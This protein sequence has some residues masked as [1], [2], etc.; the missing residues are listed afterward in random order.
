MSGLVTNN[1]NAAV[2]GCE[3]VYGINYGFLDTDSSLQGEENSFKL[4]EFIGKIEM[5]FL[6]ILREQIKFQ[7]LKDKY[8]PKSTKSYE[9]RDL[10]SSLD[11][12]QKQYSH[13]ANRKFDLINEYGNLP[14]S[15]EQEALFKATLTKINKQLDI[16][17]NITMFNSK[18][19]THCKKLK[20][21]N[22]CIIL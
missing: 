5:L 1:P 12:I 13:F 3:P 9:P 7:Q 21:N 8:D 14:L 4:Q 2:S 10:M 6:D 20:C 18:V 11:E 17:D 19:L 16:F 15:F 22:L